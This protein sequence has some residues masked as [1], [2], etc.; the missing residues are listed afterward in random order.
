MCISL[1]FHYTI[2]A[3]FKSITGMTV[4]HSVN[5]VIVEGIRAAKRQ[6]TTR[7]IRTQAKRDAR[8]KFRFLYALHAIVYDVR[9]AQ[10]ST[11]TYTRICPSEWKRDS[12][13]FDEEG[14][15]TTLYASE[16]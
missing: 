4:T 14:D 9:V 13:G 10:Q 8:R 12:R 2:L 11:R 5:L 3:V 15:G 6:F 7:Q 1:K 16:I